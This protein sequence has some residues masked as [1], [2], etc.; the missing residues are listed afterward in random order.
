MSGTALTPWAFRSKAW[1][2]RTSAKLAAALGCPAQPSDQ[3]LECLM[4][5]PAA[6]IIGQ[7]A[8]FQEWG[9][10]PMCVFSM[11]QEPAGPGAFLDKHPAAAAAAGPASD[12]PLVIGFTSDE[13]GIVAIQPYNDFSMLLAEA[14]TS[15]PNQQT[16]KRGGKSH[17]QEDYKILD[18][19]YILV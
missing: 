4:A 15:V 16:Y 14:P 5:K 18:S 8:T 2:A 1:T 6:D 7:D 12:V 13:G 17:V 19:R 9:D 11:A 3:L 10:H